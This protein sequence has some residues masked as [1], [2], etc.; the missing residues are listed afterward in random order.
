MDIHAKV[1]RRFAHPA[2]PDALD[3]NREVFRINRDGGEEGL[4]I[5]TSA[6]DPRMFLVNVFG[7]TLVPMIASD[8]L[9]RRRVDMQIRDVFH[10]ND[11]IDMRVPIDHQNHLL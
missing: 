4:T 3:A 10:S 7:V 8:P 9:I 5:G 1:R 6:R 11:L 2:A